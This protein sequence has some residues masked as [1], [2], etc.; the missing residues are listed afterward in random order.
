LLRRLER[1]EAGIEEL[2]RRAAEGEKPEPRASNA[3]SSDG[4]KN[5]ELRLSDLTASFD[6][7]RRT[8]AREGELAARLE[9]AEGAL[10]E[11]K[12]LRPGRE[13]RLKADLEA[14]APKDEVDALRVNVSGALGSLEEIKLSF[15]QYS[16]EFARVERGCS[17]ALGEMRGFVKNAEQKPLAEKFDEYLKESVARVSDR[18]AEV[19]T[20]MH[21]GLSEMSGRLLAAEILYKKMF[22]DAEE[23]LRK[24][25]EPELKS[26]DGQ[27]RWLRE[28]M[29]RLSDEYTVVAERKMRALEGKYSAFEAIARRMDAIDA[30][31]KTGGKIGLP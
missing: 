18:L 7:L 25:V 3:A 27:L 15:A 17:K 24:S 5:I 1:A 6:G 2:R 21:S 4:I 20:A 29:I 11:I 8:F 26:I 28:N 12:T 9:Q 23:R 22:A 13:A 14:L 16:E 31:L 10:A 30:A 19:E